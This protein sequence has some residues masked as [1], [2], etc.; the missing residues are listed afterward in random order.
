M[1]QDFSRGYMVLNTQLEQNEFPQEKILPL[2]NDFVFKKVFGENK[3]ILADLL[4]S[5]TGF[6][7]SEF[8]NLVFENTH[9]TGNADEDKECIYDIKVCTASNHPINI[10][11]QVRNHPWFLNRV[12]FYAGRL[13]T[14]QLKTGNK[15]HLLKKAVSI[16]ITS[17]SII[18]DEHWCHNLVWYDKKRKWELPDSSEIILLELPKVGSAVGPLADWLRLI[19]A[20]TEEEYMQVARQSEELMKAYGIIQSLSL[21]SGTRY[22]AQMREKY[23]RDQIAREDGAYE[24]G[25]RDTEARVMQE[26]ESKIDKAK[27]ETALNFLRM[28]LSP[29]KVAQG[30]GMDVDEV[31]RIKES[32]M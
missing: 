14:D 13:Y 20:K 30:T 16:I 5:A 7:A 28:G 22:Y 2:T 6:P 15:Y 8:E 32:L 10:E 18:D 25:V 26:A 27:K 21:D 12:Q 17:F 11:I 19:Y 31:Y 29:E 9:S 4:A 1:R 24:K 23:L 3:D